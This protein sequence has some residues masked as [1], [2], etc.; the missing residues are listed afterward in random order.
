MLVHNAH[1]Y[2]IFEAYRNVQLTKLGHI[3]NN[4]IRLLK[5]LLK[6]T[7]SVIYIAINQKGIKYEG[8]KAE[9]FFMLL[10]RKNW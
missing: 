6:I 1:I 9:Y 8:E 3:D 2:S 4:D 10:V 7:K 5:Y